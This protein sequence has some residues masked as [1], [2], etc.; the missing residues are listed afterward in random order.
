M[1]GPHVASVCVYPV[2]SLRGVDVPAADVLA[3]GVQGDRRW[4]V[5]LPDG[6]VLTA[7]ELP[8]MLGVRATPVDGGIRLA[9]A[10]LPDL[11]VAEPAGGVADV[12]VGLS[13]L[14]RATSGGPRADAWLSEALGRP[15][16]LVWLDDPRRRT[17]SESHGGL[18]GDTM[19]LADAGPLLVTT[20]ASM[21]ALNGWIADAARESADP[22][23]PSRPP[24]PMER[25]RPN[26]VVGGD[27]EP[28]EED[29]WAGLRVGDVELRFSERC[30]RCSLTTID[31]D[32]LVTTKEPVRTLAR[33]RRADGRTWFGVR[34]VPVT[35]GR[36]HVGDPV[37]SLR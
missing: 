24:L 21:A 28:F 36:V 8:R 30:D 13:R 6:E 12:P 37:T 26:L 2:K 31:L 18:P 33:H 14:D 1:V 17:V 29:T 19:A 34:V 10:G 22:D 35:T 5:V 7:R 23:G 15:V 11:E 9:A 4:M 27:L 20:V 25:F 16:R 32:A 3:W